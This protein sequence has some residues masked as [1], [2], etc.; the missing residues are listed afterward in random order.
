MVLTNAAADTIG[1]TEGFDWKACP[2][3]ISEQ[4]MAKSGFSILQL[5]TNV[6]EQA[7]KR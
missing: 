1:E 5:I 2:R 7:C 6:G 4:E 3:C